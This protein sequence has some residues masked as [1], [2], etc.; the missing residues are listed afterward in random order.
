MSPRLSCLPRKRLLDEYFIEN[1]TKLL[2]IAA[3]VDRLDRADG[4]D[5][6]DFRLH[7]F[8][9]ALKLLAGS[10]APR[11]QAIQMLFSDPTTDPLDKAN[12]KNA[13]GAYDHT[14]DGVSATTGKTK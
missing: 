12:A 5:E 4:A 10:K 2:D 6:N 13:V 11:V 14:Q 1:R 3:F 9:E 7:V 8:I